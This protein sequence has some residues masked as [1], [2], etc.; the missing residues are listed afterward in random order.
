MDADKPVDSAHVEEST[1]VTKGLADAKLAQYSET[2]S[3]D[4]DMPMKVAIS[5]YWRSA[6]YCLFFCMSAVLWGYDMQVNGGLLAAS[7]FRAVF[8]YTLPGGETILPA[9]WQAAFNMIATVGGMIGSLLCGPLS[10]YIGRKSNLALACVISTGAVFLQFFAFQRG[11]LLAGKLVNGIALGMFLVT[12]CAYCSESSPVALRG[13]TTA[14]VNLFVVIGQLLG[15]CLIKAFGS[16]SDTFAYRIPFAFQWLF[17]VILISGVWFCPESPY[18]YV[19]RGRIEEAR[20]SLERFQVGGSVDQW[21]H[22][23]QE[24]VRM[25]EESAN[26]AGYIDCFRGTDLRRTMIIFCVWTINSLTGVNFVLSYSTYFFEIAGLPTSRSFDMGVGVTAVGVVGN[27]C[28]WYVI[29]VIGRR[30]L[31]PGVG[32]LMVIVFIIAILDVVPGYNSSMAWGQSALIIVWNFFY[33]LTLGPLGYVICGEM[34]STRLRS[35]VVSIGF[36]TQNLWTLIMTITVPY[37]INPDEGNLRGKTGFIFAFFSALAFVW[38]YFC[39]PETKGRSYEELD[40]MFEQK[41]PARKFCKYRRET[42]E[43]SCISP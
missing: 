7:Q 36:F 5:N 42:E 23:I 3:R 43:N 39:L 38:T 19:Q 2:Q 30:S 37:M 29:N 1:P 40:H 18:W 14:M 27:I 25:E 20:K 41:I 24:T 34:S 6:A 17:P 12:A 8:G 26:S 15:N 22:E 21:L 33:D 13:L 4:H 16:R 28:S 9:R 35:H 10:P 31:V 32:V 11:V